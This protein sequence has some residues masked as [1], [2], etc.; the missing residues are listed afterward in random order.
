MKRRKLLSFVFYVNLAVVVVILGYRVYLYASAP[1]AS[2]LLV[3]EINQ[4]ETMTSDDTR[5]SFAVVGEANNSIGLFEKQ[6]IPRINAGPAE[7][8]VSAGNI[9]SGGSEDKYRAILGTLSHLAKPYLLTFGE[10]EFDEFGSSRFYQRFGPHFYSL[11]LRQ[12]QFVFLD[13]TGR[14]PTDWQERWLR[15]ILKTGDDRPVI[16]FAGHPLVDPVAETLFEPDQGA[17]S[18]PKDRDRL[19]HL[20]R[21]LGVELV[22]SAGASTYSDQT[23]DSIR[24]IVTGGAGGLVLNDATSFYHYLKVEVGP[25]GTKVQMVQIDTAPTAMARRI[26][27][28]WFYVYSL[29][30]VGIWNFLLI[31]SGFVIVGVYLFNRLFRERHYYPSYDVGAA[32]DLGRPMRITMFT[33]SYLPFIGGVPVSVDRLRRGLEA[34]GHKVQVICPSYGEAESDPGV[35]RVPTLLPTGAMIRIANPL[36]R[37]TRRE[38]RAFAPDIIHIHHPYWLGELGLQMARAL[39]VPAIFTYHTR[40]EQFAHIVPLPGA[41]FRNVVAHW[42]ISRFANRCSRIIVPTPV[43]RDYIR[44]IGITSPVD[45]QPTG[46]EIERFSAPEPAL[47]K[48][49]QGQEN[50]DGRLVL[51]TVSRLSKEKN[52]TFII[53]AMAELKRRSAP[54]FRLLVLGGGEERSA[55]EALI[56]QLDLGG[57]VTLLGDVASEDVPAYLGISDVF[58]FASASETQGMVVLEAMAA[59]LPVVAVNSSGIDAFV[60]A[61]H[62][63]FVTREATSDWA[64]AVLGLLRDSAVREKMAEAARASAAQYSVERFSRNVLVCYEMALTRKD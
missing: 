19:L 30:Y 29:F 62:T 46:V 27:G 44:L 12:V 58:V 47:M 32:V 8:V 24:H 4:I 53:H 9:V 57:D 63:G 52:V 18:R 38:V 50:P 17:W 20:L 3:H 51:V 11:D 54:A 56:E 6:I 21:G 28:L 59:R 48:K 2:A 43:T 45:V 36:H 23:V 14:T 61:G 34:Q 1:D 40:L 33:N 5:V 15:D 39:N 60:E 49:L 42:I 26:E 35:L 41:L 64:T 10:H 7:F 22:I 25:D 16:V 55:L 31:F 37:R 13:T